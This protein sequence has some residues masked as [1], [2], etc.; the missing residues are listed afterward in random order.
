M[1]SLIVLSARTRHIAR[2]LSQPHCAFTCL[3]LYTHILVPFLIGRARDCRGLKYKAAKLG[4]TNLQLLSFESLWNPLP[5]GAAIMPLPL[6]T[7]A[8]ILGVN[9]M[10]PPL[11]LPGG[12]AAVQQAK[13]IR[14]MG[15]GL[16]ISTIRGSSNLLAIF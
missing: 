6:H 13:F 3:P 9:M 10:P 8:D 14:A 4:R 12:Y 5:H 2:S 1:S 16:S 11:V 7:Y 15:T